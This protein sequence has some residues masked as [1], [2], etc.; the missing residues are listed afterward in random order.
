M[1]FVDNRDVH[2]QVSEL[3]A[4]KVVGLHF[5]EGED[6]HRV[7]EEG[8][9]SVLGLEDLLFSHELHIDEREK[10]LTRHL[11]HRSTRVHRC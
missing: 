11:T 8:A 7:E 4:S 1:D 3:G 9:Y 2:V 6:R 5:V 10:K